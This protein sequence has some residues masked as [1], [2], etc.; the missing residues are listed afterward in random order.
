VPCRPTSTRAPCSWH[1][2]NSNQILEIG[3]F[4]HPRTREI[5]DTLPAPPAVGCCTLRLVALVDR[6][7]RMGWVIKT[8]SASGFGLLYLLA[9]LKPLRLCSLHFASEKEGLDR[10]HNLVVASGQTGY[11]LAV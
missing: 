7:T 11:A 2:H 9:M 3:D 8:T 4:F 10:R 1:P 5:A 6:I